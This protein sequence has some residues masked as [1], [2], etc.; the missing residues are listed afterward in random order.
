MNKLRILAVDDEWL[1]LSRI[2]ALLRRVPGVE[3]AGVA[4]TAAE[5]LARIGEGG[6]DLVLLDVR[7]TGSDGFD[8]AAALHA[9]D[10]PQVIF[11]TGF[12]EY[13][14]RAFD[15]AATDFLTKPVELER[16]R[17]ALSRARAVARARSAVAQLSTGHLAS[18]EEPLWLERREGSVRLRPSE[19]VWVEAEGDYIRIHADGASYFV[20]RTLSRLEAELPAERFLRISRSA[21]I[22]IARL[23]EVERRGR[24]GS[25]I[26]LD[27]GRQLK[28]GRS[29]LARVWQRLG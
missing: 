13:A 7:L 9:P 27:N 19:I 5:A 26:T 3:L 8:V 20:R 11:V 21:L 14:V 29:H 2:E 4:R 24:K 6:L 15:V 18:E 28:I 12:D 1:A 25:W 22:Q 23:R 10:A 17:R 16:M